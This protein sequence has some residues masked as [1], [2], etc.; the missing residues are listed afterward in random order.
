MNICIL[1]ELLQFSKCDINKILFKF[2]SI[3]YNCDI[4]SVASMRCEEKKICI[5]KV[6]DKNVVKQAKHS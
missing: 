1:Y 2:F 3:C 5:K 6:W 4:I